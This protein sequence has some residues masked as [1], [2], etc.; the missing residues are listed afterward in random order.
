[1]EVCPDLVVKVMG[2]W[3]LVEWP[4][5]RGR[6]HIFFPPF[7]EYDYHG[8]VAQPVSQLRAGVQIAEI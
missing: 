6:A 4:S 3:F 8:V 5:W 2:R 1:M 7:C